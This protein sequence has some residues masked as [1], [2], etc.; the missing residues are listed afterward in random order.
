MHQVW[1][2]HERG[3][4]GLQSHRCWASFKRKPRA[5]LEFHPEVWVTLGQKQG[6]HPTWPKTTNINTNNMTVHISPNPSSILGGQP[7]AEL[8]GGL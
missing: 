7:C 6:F 5:I 4:D 8:P 2:S 3:Q 1:V